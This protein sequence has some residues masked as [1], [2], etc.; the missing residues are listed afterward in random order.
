[1]PNEGNNILKQRFPNHYFPNHALK[2]PVFP[3]FPSFSR[4]EVGDS[5]S[6][7]PIVTCFLVEGFLRKE[8]TASLKIRF[9]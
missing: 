4:S 8:N 6:P 7:E 5:L 3:G 2:N 9:F 1:M